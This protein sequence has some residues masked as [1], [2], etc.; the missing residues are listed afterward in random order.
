MI[1]NYETGF[2]SEDVSVPKELEEYFQSI[3]RVDKLR[4][5]RVLRGFNRL[6]YPDPFS[7]EKHHI[8]P[9]T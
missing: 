2:L 6:Y 4:E 1:V 9:I 5:I 7:E 3:V 8:L